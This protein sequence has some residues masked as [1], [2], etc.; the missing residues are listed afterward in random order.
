M[1]IGV[2]TDWTSKNNY[3]QIMQCW[4]LQQVL[5]K[6]GHDPYLIRFLR[7]D[8]SKAPAYNPSTCEKIAR[9]FRKI[10][11]VILIYP[12]YRTYK[13]NKTRRQKLEDIRKK[14]E[15][16]KQK[17]EERKFTE[18]LSKHIKLSPIVYQEYKNLYSN[19]PIADAYITGSDQVWNYE[20]HPSETQAFFLQ[21]GKPTVKRIAY[22]PSIGHD[23]WPKER[24]H[25]LKQYLSSFDAISVRE[26]SGVNVCKSVGFNALHVLD[27]TLL[28]T[29]DDYLSL[30]PHSLH[31]TKT[32]HPF[33]FI[34]SLNYCNTQDIDIDKIK[35]YAKLNSLNIKVTP[36]TG[37]TICS[38]LFDGVEYA[39]ATIPQWIQNIVDSELVITASFHGVVF[40]ILCHKKFMYTPLKGK[41]SHGNSRILELLHDLNLTNQIEDRDKDIQDYINCKIN[42]DAVD[43]KLKDMREASYNYLINSLKQNNK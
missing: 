12:A 31:K 34:Y 1:K 37:Y 6:L 2:I 25:E 42:W 28:M 18:F 22:A 27:P 19:P 33:I 8:W 7:F 10:I 32:L 3:G 14:N 16:V 23:D 35:K 26:A 11:K 24:K 9:Y 30:L 15:Y 4:A 38:E 40:S 43:E 20:I 29:K 5:K 17:D 21:F 39:Y 41:Y 36:S 13:R